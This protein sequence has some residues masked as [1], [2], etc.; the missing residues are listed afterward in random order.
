MSTQEDEHAKLLAQ[1]N[2]EL[3]VYGQMSED[4]A[5]S[6][7]DYDSGVKGLSKATKL[8][9]QGVKNLGAAVGKTATA[10]YE[11]KQGA[12]AYD[13]ALDS[14][15][16]AADNASKA[17]F[18]L[19]G[20]FGMIA[21]AIAFLIGKAIKAAKVV[22]E[23]LTN[24]YSAYQELSKS[25]A[26][27]GEGM[28]NAFEGIQKLRMNVTDFKK[29]GDLIA[30]NAKE[31]A[32]FGGTVSQGRKKFEDA[33]QALEPYRLTLLKLGEATDRQATGMAAFIVSET[34]MGRA[35]NK[36][37]VDMAASYEAY[38]KEQDLLN[39]I[40]GTERTEREAARGEAL[41]EQQYASTLRILQLNN[42]EDTAKN[43]EAVNDIL[44]V[45]NPELA[46]AFRSGI[47]GNLA[48]QAS[49]KLFQTTQGKSAELN[50]KLA[51]KLITPK[52]Y[53]D[54]LNTAVKQFSD[55]AGNMAAQTENNDN[56]ALTY[57]AQLIARNNTTVGL[58]EREKAARK[59]QDDQLNKLDKSTLNM[60]EAEI[61]NT[62]AMLAAQK[63]IQAAAPLASKAMLTMAQATE[64]A[65]RRA[66]GLAETSWYDSL[67]KASTKGASDEELVAT[68][69]G[70]YVAP[71][72]IT[73]KSAAPPTA[74][75]MVPG[76]TGTP[77]RSGNQPSAPPTPKPE[78]KPIPPPPA[79]KKD[80]I[81][82]APPIEK[83]IKFGNASGDKRHFDMLDP[84]FQTSLLK[85]LAAYQEKGGGK[86]N[87]A[88]ATRTDEEQLG[89]Y[90]RWLK[91][92]PPGVKSPKDKGAID[93]FD[94]VTTPAMPMSLGG[95]GSHHMK[96]LA[97]DA[98]Q[99][100][101]DIN[102]KIKLADFGLA[103]GGN[104]TPSD[105][106]HIQ[107]AAEGGVFPATPGGQQ[108]L[109]AEAG[110]DEAVIPMKDGAVQVSMKNPGP[111][112]DMATPDIDAMLNEEFSSTVSADIKEDL[113]A[114][115]MD[116]VRQ[117]QPV[118]A[119][120]SGISQAVLDQLDQLIAY[121]KEANDIDNRMLAVASN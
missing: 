47:T 109:L 16:D 6:L 112:T 28:E 5:D 72:E 68:G 41:K 35:Q 43:F 61:A 18:M 39:K 13:G 9:Y 94:G 38:V 10:M 58:I 67:F 37:D 80:D 14:M 49:S 87:L 106:V 8:A 31:L 12:S 7:A 56:F 17:L 104:F 93:T 100:A 114:V 11:G 75:P 97:I 54:Q 74:P 113:R 1:A 27:A 98:G 77:S 111:M 34:R 22:N 107:R 82:K 115:V 81:A 88:S 44:S 78:P 89:L 65:S 73:P 50:D 30:T 33:T 103:W 63:T 76:G 2:Y 120:S 60:A 121:Q 55:G 71:I 19:G 62:N 21:G 3:T 42:Q 25:G 99:Q 101:A 79:P 66:L 86:L 102:G 48:S 118:S 15:S 57:N 64:K 90:N 40:T 36:R 4:T 29:Y 51:K 92:Q 32:I 96:G 20:P 105:P 45:S 91:G 53:V 83:F 95:V 23:Q 84:G 24:N 26:A 52:E 70:E 119:S 46:Q 69:G 116:I 117:L 108:V 59:E 85:A 110:Q